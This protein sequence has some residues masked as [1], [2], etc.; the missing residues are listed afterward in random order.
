MQPSP[1]PPPPQHLLC[2]DALVTLSHS[3][4]MLVDFLR[5]AAGPTPV[6]YPRVIIFETEK[7]QHVLYL[8]PLCRHACILHQAIAWLVI[9]FSGC[10][11]SHGPNHF[12]RHSD[13]INKSSG[14]Q[15][16]PRHTSI[17]RHMSHINVRVPSVCM[18]VQRLRST[19]QRWT[20]HVNCSNAIVF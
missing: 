7:Q 5:Q 2:A 15:N 16:D 1:C 19:I 8:C 20:I 9:S 14:G 13:T 3:V 11:L 6:M 17:T 10:R 4:V 12:C 18:A